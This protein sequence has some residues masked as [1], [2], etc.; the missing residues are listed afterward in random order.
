MVALSG[1]VK[2]WI[3]AA[4]RRRRRTCLA[5]SGSCW[6]VRREAIEDCALCSATLAPIVVRAEHW[7][8]V[9]NRNQNLLGK[10]MIVL[11]RHEES[12]THLTQEEWRELQV[13][14]ERTTGSL[15]S[16]FSPDHFNYVFLQNVDRHVHL[17]VVP[18]YAQ[19][20]AAVGE[21][22]VDS[23]WPAHYAVGETSRLRRPQHD[24]LARMRAQHLEQHG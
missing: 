3:P 6:R 20:R 18:R 4:G 17:H 24:P 16:A 22:F 2:R 1:R 21:R 13:L 7:L 23:T 5:V 8:V 9:L 19:S 10:S 12:V 14:I 11:A 15:T